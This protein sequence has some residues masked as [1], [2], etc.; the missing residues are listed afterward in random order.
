[1]KLYRSHAYETGPA[2]TAL[3]TGHILASRGLTKGK[4]DGNSHLLKNFVCAS[5]LLSHLI[6]N[7]VVWYFHYPYLYVRKLRHIQ[8]KGLA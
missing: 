4:K 1:M 7:P 2:G 5:H 6:N 8:V 3:T